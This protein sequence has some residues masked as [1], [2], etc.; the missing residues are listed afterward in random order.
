MSE[1][2]KRERRQRALVAQT[3]AAYQCGASTLERLSQALQVLTLELRLFPKDW[4]ADFQAEVN[5]LEVLYAVALDRGVAEDLPTG[6]QAEADETVRR[7][8]AL[9]EQLPP[10]AGDGA[11]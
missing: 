10:L 1:A 8:E 6:Y 11:P 9:L 2:A 5:G 3:L 4:L 7:L